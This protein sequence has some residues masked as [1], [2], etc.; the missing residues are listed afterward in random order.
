MSAYRRS[1]VAAQGEPPEGFQIHRL[2]GNNGCINPAHLVAVSAEDHRKLHA[3]DSF[4]QVPTRASLEREVSDEAPAKE[5]DEVVDAWVR[6]KEAEH[7]G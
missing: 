1:Y 3:R 5:I 7:G 2:C 6:K 4:C